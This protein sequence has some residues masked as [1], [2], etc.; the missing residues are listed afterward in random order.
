MFSLVFWGLLFCSVFVWGDVLFCL[1][2]YTFLWE[3][4]AGKYHIGIQLMG[5]RRRLKTKR[6]QAHT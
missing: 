4:K 2:T 5:N 3:L 1:I 6:V